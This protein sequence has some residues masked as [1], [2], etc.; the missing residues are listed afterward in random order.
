VN[1]SEQADAGRLVVARVEVQWKSLHVL[2]K[3]PISV[4]YCA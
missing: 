1:V 3:L 2:K 4:T